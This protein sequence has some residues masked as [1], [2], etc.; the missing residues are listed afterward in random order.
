MTSCSASPGPCGPDAYPLPCQAHAAPSRAKRA[1]NTRAISAFRQVKRAYREPKVPTRGANQ[2]GAGRP[3]GHTGCWPAPA[4]PACPARIQ[5][6]AGDLRVMRA[7]GGVRVLVDRAAQDGF[8][9]DVLRAGAGHGG[10]GRVMFA[11]RDA[12]GRWPGTAGPC[13]SAPGEAACSGL[14]VTRLQP[15]DD[16]PD[17]GDEPGPQLRS[18]N[19]QP[20]GVAATSSTDANPFAFQQVVEPVAI[21]QVVQR[22]GQHVQRGVPGGPGAGPSREPPRP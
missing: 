17:R 11:A 22:P 3:T 7:S 20:S 1:V 2:P 13:C 16:L 18:S 5:D 19:Q 6:S 9:A 21:R 8:S 14:R 10:A 12:L 4:S 15:G